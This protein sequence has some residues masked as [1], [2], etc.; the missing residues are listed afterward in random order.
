MPCPALPAVPRLALPSL[1]EPRH[2]CPALPRHAVP[3]PALPATMTG[4]LSMPRSVLPALFLGRYQEAF[5]FFESVFDV[6]REL[7][8]RRQ[9][10]PIV[11]QV[12]HNVGHNLP[13]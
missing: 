6:R 8:E 12:S 5:Q 7:L 11:A 4:A 3:S 1:A 10:V 13:P 9:L 2:A